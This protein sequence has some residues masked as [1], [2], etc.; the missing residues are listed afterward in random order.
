MARIVAS[1][2]LAVNFAGTVTTAEVTFS[3]SGKLHLTEQGE[4]ADCLLYKGKSNAF[5]IRVYDEAGNTH[6]CFPNTFTIIQGFDIGSAV[7]PYS[8]GIEV[9]NS[10]KGVALF[11]P[12]KGLEKNQDLPRHGA[13][14]DGRGHRICGTRGHS[15]GV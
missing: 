1:V 2:W 7:L 9:W 10:S 8:I 3:S 5:S 12:I 14:A 13:A 11:T 6:P 4:I 15:A